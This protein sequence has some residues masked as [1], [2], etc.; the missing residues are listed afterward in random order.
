MAKSWLKDG[1]GYIAKL[2]AKIIANIVVD[3]SG[4]WLWQRSF[5]NNGYGQCRAW[6]KNMTAHKVSHLIFI[7]PVG[8]G[9]DVHHT[10]DVRSCVNPAHLQ[11]ISH[12]ENIHDLL[13]KGR[14]SNGYMKGTH[15]PIRD[16][17]GQFC[18]DMGLPDEDC[19]Y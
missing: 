18:S 16:D 1:T 15:A 2:K 11:Q 4:C 7:G 6:G 10:C 3:A 12:K 13:S 8:D 14:M 9:M 5:K 19:L 17:Q